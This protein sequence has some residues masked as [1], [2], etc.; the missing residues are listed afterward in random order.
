M[1][2]FKTKILPKDDSPSLINN[3]SNKPTVL[4][5]ITVV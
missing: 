5:G 3:L 4:D 2:A 1:R